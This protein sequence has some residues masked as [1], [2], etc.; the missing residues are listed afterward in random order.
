MRLAC[1]AYH[2]LEKE[3]P[4]A[5]L[6]SGLKKKSRH[7]QMRLQRRTKISCVTVLSGS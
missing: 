5:R 2:I 1:S 4:L 7:C 3:V 6:S